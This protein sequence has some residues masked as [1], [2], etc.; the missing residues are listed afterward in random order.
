[1]AA[2]VTT[3]ANFDS[4]TAVV[5]FQA[6]PRQPILVSDLFVYDVSRDGQGFINTPVKHTET[7]PLSLVLNWHANLSN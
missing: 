1:M 6:A 4:R 7:Q 2:Q 3:G 5:L